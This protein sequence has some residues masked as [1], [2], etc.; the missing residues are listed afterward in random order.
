MLLS[1]LSILFLVTTA[2]LIH[3][4]A[5][6]LLT[7]TISKI[8]ASPRLSILIGILGCL[9]AHLLEVTLFAGGFYFLIQ[10]ESLGSLLGGDIQGHGLFGTPST[11]FIDSLYFSLTCYTS[12]GFGD[13]APTGWLRFLAGIEAL[14]GL[15]LIAWTASFMYLEMQ[16]HWKVK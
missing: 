9:C 6:N 14:T 2:V 10:Q 15:L 5:L 13:L 3:F 12:L 8:K 16:K 7:G 1:I 4:E 11:G